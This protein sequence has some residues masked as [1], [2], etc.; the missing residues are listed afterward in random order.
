MSTDVWARIHAREQQQRYSEL[1]AMHMEKS[2]RAGDH[3]W[4]MAQMM[5]G[6][7]DYDAGYDDGEQ[8]EIK[9]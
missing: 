6:S 1:A 5:T 4:R 2:K 7:G 3:H 8:K 9:G